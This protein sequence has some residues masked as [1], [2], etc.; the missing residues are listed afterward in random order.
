MYYENVL[1]RAQSDD[2]EGGK[3]QIILGCIIAHE[4]GHLLLGSNSH[5]DTGI[6][7]ARWEVNQL[8]QLMM[9]GLLFTPGESKRM[10]LEARS[11]TDR[12]SLAS[13]SAPQH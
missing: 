5:S 6:M 8:R 12:Q 4:L 11:R 1:R 13:T 9:G 3:L 10:G 7:L 2:A